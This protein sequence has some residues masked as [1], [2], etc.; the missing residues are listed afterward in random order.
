[1]ARTLRIIARVHLG[2]RGGWP[3]GVAS[4]FN[5][6]GDGVSARVCK[7]KISSLVF[8]NT[9]ERGTN[10]RIAPPLWSPLSTKGR[11]V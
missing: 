4:D 7:L 3:A 10:P 5:R 8:A 2:A 11:G 1:M 6:R 9:D